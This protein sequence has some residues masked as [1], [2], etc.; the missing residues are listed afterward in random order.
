M[1]EQKNTLERSLTLPLITLYGLGNI[2]GAGIYVLVGK[3]ASTAGIFTPLSFLLASIIA[4]LTAF[5]YAELSTR[6]PVSA[7]E[8]VYLQAGFNLK[9]LSSGVGLLIKLCPVSGKSVW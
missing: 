9:L 5:T 7:G 8:A 3:V 6:Y 2:L 1:S 4:G